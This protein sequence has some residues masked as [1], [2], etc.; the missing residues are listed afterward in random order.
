MVLAAGR[1]VSGIAPGDLV[2]VPRARHAS[3]VTVPAEW[4]SVVPGGVAV[5][6]AALVYLAV[7]SGYGVRRA[8]PI[9]GEP[10]CV[11][12]AGPIGA[13]AQRLVALQDPGP[14]T[15][16]ARTRRHEEAA[17]RNGAA[18]F[19]TADEPLDGIEAADRDRGHRRPRCAAERPS[20][21]PATGRRSC[22]SARRA[23]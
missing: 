2:A 19:V 16:V 11:L 5:E 8:G 22:C 6:Q 4:A 14:V 15:V 18:N 13:L 1:D 12:G 21:P 23:G 17:V 10:V 7:I 9:A 3:V 20:R